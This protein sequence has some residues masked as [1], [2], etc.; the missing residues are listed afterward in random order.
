LPGLIKTFE[1]L[2]PYAGKLA[3]AVLRGAGG[4]KATCS[5]D[6]SQNWELILQILPKN[7]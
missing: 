5:L 4:R 3:R 7:R 1:R 2:E 6:Y